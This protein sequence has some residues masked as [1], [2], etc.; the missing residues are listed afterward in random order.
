MV[1]FRG[2]YELFML[3]YAPLTLRDPRPR[4]DSYFLMRATTKLNSED[5]CVDSRISIF[6]NP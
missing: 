5:T 3:A 4:K 6:L 2:S 1:R